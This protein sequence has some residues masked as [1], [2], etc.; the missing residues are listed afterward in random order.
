MVPLVLLAQTVGLGATNY[1]VDAP[2]TAPTAVPS[3]ADEFGGRKIDRTKWKYDISRNA[4]GW[5]NNER[6]YYADERSDNARIDKGSLVIEARREEALRSRFKDSGG[7]KYT[8]AKLVSRTL[9]GFGFYEVRAKL[10]CGRG[11]WPAIWMLPTSGKWPDGGEIDIMEMVGWDPHV[12]HA[13]LHSA[14]YN[15]RLGTQRGAQKTVATS[16]SEFHR[17]QLEWS[18]QAITIGVDDRAYMRVAN[19]RPRDKGA[20]PFDR[21][22]TLI[23]N[24]AVGGDWGGQK[25]IDDQAFPQ[26]MMVDYV[27]YWKAA[28]R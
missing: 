16:C 2:M 14:S 11:I 3:F 17:Y 26:A 5:F 1:T 20:W 28:G 8:S 23:L 18:P 9:Y 19:S 27:R 4:A 25:G 13:T 12:I 10:P 6:Q 24:V 15:H 21:P 7:Q 22:Y